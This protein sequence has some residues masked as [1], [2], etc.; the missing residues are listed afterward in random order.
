M[1]NSPLHCTYP[2]FSVHDFSNTVQVWYNWYMNIM[3]TLVYRRHIP[4]YCIHIT[5]VWC[6][7]STCSPSVAPVLAAVSAELV[8][9]DSTGW[10]MRCVNNKIH[11][12]IPRHPSPPPPTPGGTIG[13]LLKSVQ[14]SRE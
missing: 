9:G 11:N 10:R 12:M 13:N 6:G 1:K 2:P 5:Y 8:P 7:I 3:R 4:M 14:R